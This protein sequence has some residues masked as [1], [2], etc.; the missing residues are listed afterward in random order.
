[1]KTLEPRTSCELLS[2]NDV[3]AVS[4]LGKTTVYKLIKAGSLPA[5]KVGKKT[6]V[7]RKDVEH[8]FSSLPGISRLNGRKDNGI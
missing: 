8:F 7:F 4:G 1:M 2:I 5:R 3:R 6:V